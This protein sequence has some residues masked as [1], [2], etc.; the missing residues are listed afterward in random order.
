M[1][2]PVIALKRHPGEVSLAG[3][4]TKIQLPDG[5]TGIMFCFESKKKAREYWGKDVPLVQYEEVKD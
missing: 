5:C 4:R 1:K 3:E 2:K